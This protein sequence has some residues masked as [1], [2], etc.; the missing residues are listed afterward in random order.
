MSTVR[1]F[2]G[3]AGVAV[4]ESALVAPVLLVIVFGI[5]EFGLVYRDYL[6]V[7]DAASDAAKVGS[8]QGPYPTTDGETA[9][10][11][12]VKNARQNL[13][14]LKVQSVERVVVFKASPPGLGSAIDQVPEVCKTGAYGPNSAAKCNV[15][16][17]TEAFLAIQAD[18]DDYFR[19][20]GSG[21]GFSCGWNPADRSDGP[22]W[23]DID[24][25]GV[26]VKV[27]HD[28][29]TGF[30]GDDFTVDYAAIARLEPGSLE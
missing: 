7:T 13:S 3:D 23:D 16:S 24:Y 27:N 15:Y 5:L 22:T 29:L 25:L 28:M 6:T 14:N 19:C 30:F 2:R 26:Y 21:A 8:I 4:I 20:G 9:D 10:F 1:R 17:G 12:I 11:S 18:N